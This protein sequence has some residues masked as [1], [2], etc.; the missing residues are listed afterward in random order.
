MEPNAEPPGGGPAP[1]PAAI[2]ARNT[3]PRQ[4]AQH[5]LTVAAAQVGLILAIKVRAASGL[6]WA[7]PSFAI[8]LVLVQ[9]QQLPR[10]DGASRWIGRPTEPVACV[11]AAVWVYLMRDVLLSS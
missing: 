8:L 7:I 10:T 9:A 1:R 3:L 2:K 5:P 4:A 11:L 6:L